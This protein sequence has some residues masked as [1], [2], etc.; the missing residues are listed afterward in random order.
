[1][2][3]ISIIKWL[4]IKLQITKWSYYVLLVVS[5]GN[6]SYNLMPMKVS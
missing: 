3:D 5:N 4:I 2:C 1:M 6:K